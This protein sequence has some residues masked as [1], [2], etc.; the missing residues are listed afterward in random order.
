MEDLPINHLSILSLKNVLGFA[1]IPAPGQ[2]SAKLMGKFFELEIFF[3]FD[4]KLVV[5]VVGP[6]HLI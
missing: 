6:R 4:V 5:G 2:I 1:E 3:Y